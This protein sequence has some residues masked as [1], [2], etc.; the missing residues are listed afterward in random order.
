MTVAS[1]ASQ[2]RKL[3]SPQRPSVR[4]RSNRSS[5][6]NNRRNRWRKRRDDSPPYGVGLCTQNFSVRLKHYTTFHFERQ[7]RE[8]QSAGLSYVELAAHRRVEDMHLSAAAARINACPNAGGNSVYSEV[9][10]CELLYRLFGA[11]L[12]KTEMEVTYFPQGGALTDYTCRLFGVQVGVSVTRAMKFRGDF[13]REDA[14]KLLMKKLTGVINATQNT[15]ESWDKQILH[16]W[17]PSKH[18]ARVVTVTY[19]TLPTDVKANTVVLVTVAQ[20]NILREVFQ[21]K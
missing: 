21:N 6:Y 14:E 3:E 18:V 8:R 9:L 1:T 20:G 19:H 12:L 5:I 13:D 17:T 2:T 15:M 16:V 11:Q 7:V 4:K 10:S